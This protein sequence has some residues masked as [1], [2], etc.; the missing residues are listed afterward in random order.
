MEACTVR[1]FDV[2][3]EVG[4]PWVEVPLSKNLIYAVE[5]GVTDVKCTLRAHIGAVGVEVGR[6]ILLEVANRLSK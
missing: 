5:V 1:E 6:H 4:S 2:P 3:Q